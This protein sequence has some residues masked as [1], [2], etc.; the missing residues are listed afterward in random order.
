MK[1]DRVE[2]VVDTGDGYRN[3]EVRAT[4]AG[5]RV[6]TRIARGVVEVSEITRT[7]TPVRTARFLSNRVVAL[8]EHPAENGSLPGE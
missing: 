4:R 5:R 8:V 6:E 7:G 1:G 2:I 3:Y